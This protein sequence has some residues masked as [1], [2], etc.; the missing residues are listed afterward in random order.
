MRAFFRLPG[1]GRFV[2]ALISLAC[3]LVAATILLDV[4]YRNPSA[5][6]DELGL[7]ESLYAVFTMLFFGSAYPL[8]T[9]ALTRVVFFI[10]P[11]VGLVVIGQF[12]A[13]LAG[14]YVNRERWE[15][16]VASTY[17]GHV[18]VCGLGRVG[19][20]VARWLLD[21]GEEVV[22]IESDPK[23]QFI[24]QVR[25]WGVPVITADARRPEVLQD[26]GVMACSAICPLTGDDLINLAM[27]TEARALHPHLKVVLRTFDERLGASL[28]S[29]FDIHTAF[30]AAALAA[31]AFAAAALNVPVDYAL[32]FGE[33]EQ[34][35]LVTVTKF[36]LVA[37]SKLV[38]RTVGSLEAEFDVFVIA[39][40]S[41]EFK[42]NPPSEAVLEVDQGIVVV[43]S[44]QT[45]SALARLTPPTSELRRYHANRWPIEQ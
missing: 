42:F 33:G 25:G 10:V 22:I 43:G 32:E 13:R 26:A 39:H 17:T 38:G 6:G 23:N 21:L 5:G 14:A 8:P 31:P 35:T 36:T 45:L 18:I 19:F 28:E 34:R 40:R 4:R 29:G 9:D 7:P 37:G 15:R 30:S 16:A 44:P 11:V 41:S 20:R 24:A 1:S 12:L 3:L 2:G 27:A